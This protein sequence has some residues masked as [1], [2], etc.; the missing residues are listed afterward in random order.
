MTM[1]EP[2]S[3]PDHRAYYHPFGAMYAEPEDIGNLPTEKPQDPKDLRTD[4]IQ[5]PKEQQQQLADEAQE[6]GNKEVARSLASISP[7]MHEQLKQVDLGEAAKSLSSSGVKEQ[8]A[9]RA[10]LIRI[11]ALQEDP[12]V[13]K[14]FLQR[15]SGK[16]DE[17]WREFQ[18]ASGWK[19][20]LLSRAGAQDREKEI[21][22]AVEAAKPEG[23]WTPPQG[24]DNMYTEANKELEGFDSW[25]IFEEE[26]KKRD[27]SD[28]KTKRDDADLKTKRDEP[29]AIKT[30]KV[31]GNVR[32][33][34]LMATVSSALRRTTTSSGR[35][36]P[37]RP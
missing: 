10:A 17:A 1:A 29:A 21:T 7:E 13:F 11:A 28:L 35:L 27:D 26:P 18:H 6:A 19:D 24:L 22:Q 20:D 37:K 23:G 34:W 9:I 3:L 15:S 2:S 16:L 31:V 25:G 30:K 4:K 36:F 12:K 5:S 33:R 32:D 14:Q 8:G